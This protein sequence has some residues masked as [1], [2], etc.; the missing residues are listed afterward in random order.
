MV[1]VCVCV[2]VLLLSLTHTHTHTHTHTRAR[3][4]LLPAYHHD[5]S[6]VC[7]KINNNNNNNKSVN[8]KVLSVYA[9][10]WCVCIDNDK[11]GVLI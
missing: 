11:S 4:Y 6:A 10:W 1:C 9:V 8:M 7:T 3:A 2:C 5:C